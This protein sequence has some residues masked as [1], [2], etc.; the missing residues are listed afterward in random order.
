[1]LMNL[2]STVL[3]VAAVTVFLL[4]ER[5]FAGWNIPTIL[6]AVGAVITLV[7]FLLMFFE[8]VEGDDF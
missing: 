8:I 4:S 5:F 3:I 1:M 2:G 6:L 7:S